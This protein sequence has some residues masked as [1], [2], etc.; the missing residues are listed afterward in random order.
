MI[1]EMPDSFSG[2]IVP[3]GQ[4]ILKSS[5]I[6]YAP[7]YLYVKRKTRAGC[8]TWNLQLF[9]RNPEAAT[10]SQANSAPSISILASSKSVRKTCFSRHERIAAEGTC[11][12]RFRYSRIFH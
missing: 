6:D 7:E 4:G 12:G 3:A 11:S 9:L 5:I 10:I 1:H 2:S 8:K